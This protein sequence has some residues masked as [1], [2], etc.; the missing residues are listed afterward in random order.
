MDGAQIRK[1]SQKAEVLIEALPYIR[2]FN[3]SI[4]VIKYGGSAMVKEELKESVLLDILLMK[5]VGIRVV[6]VHGG[7]KRISELLKQLGKKA[8]FVDGLRV[9]DA[10][11]MDVA[12]MV[13]A[14]QINGEIVATLNRHGGRAVGLSGKDG[15]LLLARKKAGKVDLGQVGEVVKINS[16]LVTFLLDKDY[17]PVIAPVGVD[18]AGTTLNLNADTV[19]GSLAAALRAAKFILLTDELGVLK[20]PKDPATLIPTISVDEFHPL[21]RDGIIAGGMIPKVESCLEALH[22]GVGKSHIISG[23]VKHSLLIEIFT[24]T[25]IGTEIVL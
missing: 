25:G 10:E 2:D 24:H 22:G 5:L 17:I 15:N 16:E 18:Q 23:E 11:T 6:I 1:L 9:T 7:G 19:A 21:R 4:F 8:T 14:G 3:N 12:E 13:L 20:D